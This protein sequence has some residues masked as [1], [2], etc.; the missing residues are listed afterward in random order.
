MI[1][2]VSDFSDTPTHSGFRHARLCLGCVVAIPD[3]KREDFYIKKGKEL[4]QRL[5]SYGN[6][7][8]VNEAAEYMP[9]WQQNYWGPHYR[10][11]LSIKREVDP[12]NILTCHHCVGSE[13]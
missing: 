9:D 10:R 11:L 12:D 1:G 5:I 6:G 3:I 4:S 2:K 13:L 8:Y 7:T